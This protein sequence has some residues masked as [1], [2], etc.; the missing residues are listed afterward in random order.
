MWEGNIASDGDCQQSDG[1]VVPKIPGDHHAWLHWVPLPS[2]SPTLLPS[3]LYPEA[4]PSRLE[5]K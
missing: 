1:A 2:E 3:L 5:A 4:P